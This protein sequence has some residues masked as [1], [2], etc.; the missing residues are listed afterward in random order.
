MN[1]K[2]ILKQAITNGTEAGAKK[3][4]KGKWLDALI[5]L[6]ANPKS[7]DKIIKFVST[8][9]EA[10]IGCVRRNNE[11]VK[12]FER[13]AADMRRQGDELQAMVQANWKGI[14]KCGSEEEYLREEARIAAEIEQEMLL[15]PNRKHLGE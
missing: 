10:T 9:L 1:D 6:L 11:A 3:A 12:Q 4:A 15:K 14:K 7:P 2:P 8:G 5:K 13:E